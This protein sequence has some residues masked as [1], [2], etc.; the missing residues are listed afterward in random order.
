MTDV[1]L[2]SRVAALEE[3]DGGS[4]LNGNDFSNEPS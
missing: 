4:T 1:E 3:T 2:N